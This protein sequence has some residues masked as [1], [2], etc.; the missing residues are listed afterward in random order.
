[1]ISKHMSMSG[2]LTLFC[3]GLAYIYWKG[4]RKS[5][6]VIHLTGGGINLVL[7]IILYLR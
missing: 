1:M 7:T 6:M 2:I 3:F 4:E 5:L